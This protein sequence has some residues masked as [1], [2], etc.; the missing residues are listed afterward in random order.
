MLLPALSPSPSSVSQRSKAAPFL[1]WAG[2]KTR[3]L[4]KILPHFPETHGRY[5]E[6]FV[7][8][9][10]VFFG[11][12]PQGSVQLSDI[13]GELINVYRVVRDE[14]DALIADLQR[15]RYEKNYYYAVRAQ[16]P[17]ELRPVQRASRFIFLNRTCF[18]GL[19][20]VN[21]RGRFNVPFGR[22]SNP[23][24]CQEDRLRSASQ[25]LQGVTIGQLD[26]AT[27]CAPAQKGDVVYFD[28]PY[29]PISKTANFTSYA[30]GGFD[31]GEQERLAQLF[32]RLADDG[33]FV[34]LSNSDTPFIRS[35]YKDFRVLQIEAPRAISRNAAKRKPVHEVVV[36]SS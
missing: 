15:H 13:N 27:A 36:V 26:Y 14:V 33:V 5:F 17:V 25:A 35:L 24:I 6:P 30:S 22:Y 23:T 20:R 32:K 11:F 8:G 3:I 12:A 16:E 18:N 19:Y 28:P 9:G 21:R 7:G 1:K 31:R 4:D 29:D 2:G 10:A 34:A